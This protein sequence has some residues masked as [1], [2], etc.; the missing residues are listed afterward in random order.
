MDTI[1][2]IQVQNLKKV[3]GRLARRATLLSI[4]RRIGPKVYYTSG[5]LLIGAKVASNRR[6]KRKKRKWGGAPWRH[7]SKAALIS[8]R[9]SDLVFSKMI[10]EYE[11]GTSRV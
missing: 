2:K 5:G 8:K 6:R 9:T 7:F 11:D 10:G 4:V 3:V 1:Q